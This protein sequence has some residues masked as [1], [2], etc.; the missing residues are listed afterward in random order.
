MQETF[1][2]WAR[3]RNRH[4]ADKPLTAMNLGA[5]LD[6]AVLLVHLCFKVSGQSQ[7]EGDFIYKI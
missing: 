7:Y 5:N 3:E 4:E 6:K 2:D 1:K